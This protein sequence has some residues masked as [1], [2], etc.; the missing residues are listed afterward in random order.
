MAN[1]FLSGGL[2]GMGGFGGMNAQPTS[3]LGEFY[4]PKMARNAQIKN[5]LL[6]M[7]VGLMSEKGLGRGAELALTMGNKAQDDY[8]QQAFDAYRMKTGEDDRQRQ[9]KR[10]DKADAWTNTFNQ[11]KLEEE[12][13]PYAN[14]PKTETVWNPA[15]RRYEK[16]QW[17]NGQWVPLPVPG[18]D[19]SLSMQSTDEAPMQ[20]LDPEYA[21][22][23]E[24]E[25][26]AL[27]DPYSDE[28][29]RAIAESEG[30]AFGA[31]PHPLLGQTIGPQD[32]D[33]KSHI[34]DGRLDSV[35]PPVWGTDSYYERMT[36]QPMDM[37]MAQPPVPMPR[38]RP[39]W[40]TPGTDGYYENR[41]GEFIGHPPYSG[42]EPIPGTDEYFEQQTGRPIDLSPAPAPRRGP[43]RFGGNSLPPPSANGI[44]FQR[45]AA[46]GEAKP[47]KP[48]KAEKLTEGQS[49]D[50]GF[51]NRGT[52][53]NADLTAMETALQQQPD[54]A[55]GDIPLV[56][57]AFK[58]SDY[59][60]AERAAREFLAVVL[61]K[62]TGAAVTNQEF[63]F[64]TPMYIPTYWD[65]PATLQAKREARERFLQGMYYA[66]G[67]AQPIFDRIRQE[68]EA[69]RGQKTQLESMSDED[70]MRQLLGGQ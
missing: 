60:Q 13:S 46:E 35:R 26:D 38:P 2:L 41:D 50:V 7:G 59:R 66:S 55:M 67:T 37:G 32:H 51:F 1:S 6:G 10:E 69:T 52:Y 22:Y 62:D 53:A 54:A 47:A 65:D 19:G 5:M 11:R 31:R 64:Y 70:I 3:L 63:A 16:V 48:A 20:A 68:F 49:K 30:Q 21:P 61:R 39:N 18:A 9:R 36:G 12:N 17:M 45:T 14:A 44:G 23:P 43:G 29:N 27:N 8:R 24:E 25:Q 56:G 28:I 33:L 40:G 4:D 58:S 15:T 42:E 34:L 57:G